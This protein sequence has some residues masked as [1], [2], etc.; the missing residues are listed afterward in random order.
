MLGL[1]LMDTVIRDPWRECV[2]RIIGLTVEGSRPLRDRDAWADFELGLIDE[3]GYG[4][5]F[6]LPAAGRRLDVARM[7]REFEAGYRFVPGMEE[8]L[9]RVAPVMPVHLLSNYPCWYMDVCRLFRLERFVRGHHPSYEVGARKPAPE[10]FERVLARAGLRPSELLFVD[11]RPENVAAARAL[12]IPAL[13]FTTAAD[14]SRVLEPIL[15][16]G[17]R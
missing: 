8:L 2:E 17:G 14:L 1:D 10:Y 7:R 12:G 4:E 9:E 6:F 16:S 13:V 15:G 3:A 5:R 11:D